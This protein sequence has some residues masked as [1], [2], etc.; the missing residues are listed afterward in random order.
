MQ[1]I[2]IDEGYGGVEALVADG[3]QQWWTEAEYIHNRLNHQACAIKSEYGYIKIA[4]RTF[5]RMCP[6]GDAMECGRCK[7]KRAW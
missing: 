6:Y 2:D 4:S 3:D 1:L 7:A 5:G